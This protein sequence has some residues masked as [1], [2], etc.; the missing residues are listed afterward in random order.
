[1]NKNQQPALSL[2]VVGL[3]GLGILALTYRDFALVW[4]PVPAWVPGRA[5]IAFGCGLLMLA[6]AAGL[7]FPRTRPWAVRI[8][9]AYLL[10]WACLKL[11]DVITAPATESSWLG[12]GEL[13]LLLAGGWTLLAR[14]APLPR[15]SPLAFLTD[16]RG[17]RT[18]RYLFALSIIP[19]GLSH[20]VYLEPTTTFVPAWLP[21]RPGWAILTGAGQI[22]SGL[23]VL[24]NVLPRLAAYAEAAQITLY[25]SLVWA[26]ALIA[27]H[28][29]LNY[30]AFFVSWIFGAAAWTVAQNLPA[31]SRV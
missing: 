30:T 27:A 4:Q 23:G 24:F 13:T 14:L 9:F 29:R 10:V 11:P 20:I 15:D 25:T 26:P 18:A 1:M 5:A 6:L 28:T 22:A 3:I 31:N 8:L 21:F 12:L 16:E 7:S 19:V 17:L 2:F